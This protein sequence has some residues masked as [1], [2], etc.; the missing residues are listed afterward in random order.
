[1][2]NFTEDS[3]LQA[4]FN[5]A[6]GAFA[7]RFPLLAGSQPYFQAVLSRGR[8]MVEYVLMNYVEDTL[9]LLKMVISEGRGELEI[10]NPHNASAL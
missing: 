9:P 4:S 3:L 1:V 8:S 5:L 10:E 6:N 2:R 7:L